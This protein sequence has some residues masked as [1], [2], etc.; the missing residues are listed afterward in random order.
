MVDVSSIGSGRGR[1]PFAPLFQVGF[2]DAIHSGSHL[3]TRAVGLI[4]TPQEAEGILQEGKADLIA[5]GRGFLYN[6]RWVWHAARSMGIEPQLDRQYISI[7][8]GYW[9]FGEKATAWKQS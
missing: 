3:V 5:I 7:T 2:A 8:A 6:P 9:P 4:T 1:I